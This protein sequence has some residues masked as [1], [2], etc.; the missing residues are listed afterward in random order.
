MDDKNLN[1][2]IDTDYTPITNDEH[3][4]THVSDNSSSQFDE[5]KIDHLDE[6][7][8]NLGHFDNGVVPP[9]P[10][11]RNNKKHKFSGKKFKGFGR[12]FLSFILIVI[13]AAASGTASS[14]ATYKYLQKNSSTKSSTTTTQNGAVSFATVSSTQALTIPEIV[15]KV[16][17]AVVSISTKIQSSFGTAGEGLGTGFIFS[18]D[19][20]ILT[21]YHVIEQADQITITFYDNTTA[22]AK[23][24]NYDQNLDL[25]VIKIQGDVKV[26]GVVELGDSSSLQV[27]ESVIAIGNPLGKELSNTVTSGIISAVNRKITSSDGTEQTYLQTDAAIN[28]GNSGGPLLNASGQVIGINSAKIS[29]GSSTENASV[30]GIGFAIP[31]NIA[32]DKI[33]DLTKQLL[34][35]GIYTKDVTKEIAAQ[36]NLPIGVYIQQIQEF[37]A[38]EKAGLKPG[39]VI[40]QIN[41]TTVSTTAEINTLKNKCNA[42]DVLTITVKRNNTDV[43]IK[44]T[45]E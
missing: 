7:L 27:G 16:K 19:G 23:L 24:V 10:E 9:P 29:S 3:K 40:T 22:Q 30:E 31:I 26:P 28:S 12:K 14:I 4:F 45:L 20:Y 21:N 11:N 1:N 43:T 41:G 5:Q 38:A 39:D 32:K 37:S 8:N 42:G 17:T 33:S 44:L 13:V 34:K 2:I 36:Y 35:L 6:Q 25:A 18:E 15:S